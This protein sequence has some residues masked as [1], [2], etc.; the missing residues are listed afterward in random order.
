MGSASPLYVGP[1]RDGPHTKNGL[2]PWEEIMKKLL[3]GIAAVVMFAWS[4]MS[5]VLA[6]NSGSSSDDRGGYSGS[7]NPNGH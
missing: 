5:G 6:S 1:K 3:R 7:D 4:I 2:T